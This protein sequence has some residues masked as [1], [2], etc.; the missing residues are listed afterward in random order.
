MPFIQ[1]NADVKLLVKEVQRVAKALEHH[2][3]L[4]Y[5]YISETGTFTEL[6][7]EDDVSYSDN[8]STIRNDIK[9][10]LDNEDDDGVIE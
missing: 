1:I 10:H 7:E 3:L 5:G 8:E 9:K 4:A 6:T 2:L